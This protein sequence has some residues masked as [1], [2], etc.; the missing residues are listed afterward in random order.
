MGEADSSG[1]RGA[2]TREQYI[3]YGAAIVLVIG[4]CIGLRFF[5]GGDR[6]AAGP[7]RI[8]PSVASRTSEITAAR[9]S[10]LL[11][12]ADSAIGTDFRRIDTDD[13]QSLAAAA[14]QTAQTIYAEVEK[15][16]A[17]APPPSAAAVHAEL[18]QALAGMGD[19]IQRLGTDEEERSCPAAEASPYQ[20]LV[21]SG[22]ANQIRG[23]ARALAKVDPAFVFGKFLPPA[24]DAP[25][26]RPK[27][28]TFVKAPARRGT[29]QLKIKNGGGDTLVS[30]VP[31]A[32]QKTPLLTVYV[33]AGSDDTVDGVAAGTYFVYYATGEDWNPARQG[34]MTGCAFSKFDDTFLFRARPL[35]DTWE[36]TMTPVTGGNASTTD[37]DPDA[38]PTG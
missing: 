2:T 23:D 17:V 11:A 5:T 24:P 29:G 9:Y 12:E 14:P 28:G 16:R 35:I 26:S 1:R 25:A 32:G 15:L 7:S 22:W 38:F 10:D 31:V 37:V 20:S 8:V 18:V 4:G 33:R 27:N 30:L 13:P 19:M 6:N 3:A 36:I 34:F 21:V